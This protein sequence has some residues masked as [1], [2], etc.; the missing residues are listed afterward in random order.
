MTT[1]HGLSHV[2][3]ETNA[4][5]RRA[6]RQAAGERHMGLRVP[7]LHGESYSGLVQVTMAQ[8]DDMAMGHRDAFHV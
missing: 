4:C 6:C 2:A 5:A 1:S 3:P 7:V 8:Q